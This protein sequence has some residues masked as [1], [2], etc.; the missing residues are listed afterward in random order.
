MRAYVGTRISPN[1]IR[2]NAGFLVCTA[3]IC[4]SGWQKYRAS[5]L[6][7]TGNDSV[8][9]VFRPVEEVTACACIAS[10][11][12]KPVVGV[13]HP[14]QFVN[15]Q[16]AA[17]ASKGH[18]QN[19]RVGPPDRNGDTTLVADLHIHDAGLI[20]SIQRGVRDLSCGYD[21]ELEDGPEP[22]T[23]SMK[24]IRM[25]HCAL[26]PEGRAQTTK[27]VDASVPDTFDTLAARYLGRDPAT[28]V[29]PQKAIDRNAVK[30]E[31]TMP[32]SKDDLDSRLDALLDKLEKFLKTSS[33]SDEP[34]LIAA[35]A[36]AIDTADH[37]Q[38]V[39]EDFESRTQDYLR[40]AIVIGQPPKSAREEAARAYYQ[41]K[42][43]SDDYAN[44]TPAEDFERRTNEAREKML[45]GGK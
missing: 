22:G 5:E 2:D 37:Q 16:N 27:I 24:N 23:Y 32:K 43:A 3:A 30:D 42:W 33:D 29:I 14:S 20:D 45:G 44:L 17:W 41:R 21:Y 38:A 15:P 18:M 26:V 34:E 28:V 40:R 9:R 7:I 36:N 13:G 11:E 25:N 19:I 1:I 10:A 4:R 6:G 31:D 8:V 39:A 12:G 35:R